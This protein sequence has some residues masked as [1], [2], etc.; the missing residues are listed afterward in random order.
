MYLILKM[1]YNSFKIYVTLQDQIYKIYN[2]F[3]T[4]I[5]LF[6]NEINF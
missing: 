5:V 3:N 6:L 2:V 4:I 1:F